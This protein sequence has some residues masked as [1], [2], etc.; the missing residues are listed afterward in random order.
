MAASTPEHGSL[1]MGVEETLPGTL[2]SSPWAPGSAQIT[3]ILFLVQKPP[4]WVA[5][6]AFGV[7]DVCSEG[8]TRPTGV[9]Q[10]FFLNCELIPTYFFTLTNIY[11]FF[12]KED[13]P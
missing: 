8:L 11:I 3:K 5:E 10:F 1:P 9:K 7:G 4:S 6:N 2:A 12:G 13:W